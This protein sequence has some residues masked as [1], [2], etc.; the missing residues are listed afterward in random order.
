MIIRSTLFI[1]LTAFNGVAASAQSVPCLRLAGPFAVNRPAEIDSTDVNGK[2]FDM[3][4]LLDAVDIDTP[5]ADTFSGGRAPGLQGQTAV[6]VVSFYLNNSSYVKGQLTVSAPKHHSLYI[7]GEK[8]TAGEQTFT[9]GHHTVQLKYLVEPADSDSLCIGLDS[10]LLPLATTDEHH[11]YDLH[12]LFDGRRV[13]GISL[14]A[15]GRYAL[16]SYQTTQRGGNSEW[17]RALVETA[18]GRQLWLHRYDAETITWMPRSERLL[19]ETKEQG[20]RRL[21]AVD[22]LTDERQLIA[23][24][25]PEGSYTMSPTEDFLILYKEQKGPKEL[26]DDVFEIVDPDDRQPGHRDRSTLWRMDLRSG[27]CQPLLFGRGRTWVSS[28]SDDGRTALVAAARMRLERRPTTVTTYMLMDMQTLHID[29]LLCDAEF[30]D[31]GDLSPDG[32]HILFKGS[33]EAFDRVGCTLPADCTPQMMDYQ[34]YL[35]DI[36]TGQVT[37][38]TRDFDPSVQTVRWHRAN[39]M[40]YFT[41]ETG[42]RVLLYQLD[43]TRSGQRPTPVSGQQGDYIYAF[44]MAAM[45]PVACYLSYKTMEPASAY[46]LH[47]D[48][49]AAKGRRAA[50]RQLKLFDGATAIGTA[51]LG[52]CHDWTFLSARGDSVHGRYYLPADFD[53][54]RRYPMIVYYYGG[55][56]PVSRYFESPYAPQWWNALGYVAYILQPSGCTGYGQQWSARHVNTAGHGPAEDIIEGTRRFCREHSFIDST[57][58]GCMGASYGGFMTQYLQTQT[59]FFAAAVSHAGISNHASYWGE[60]YWGYS[61]SEVSM[62]NSYPWTHP[63]LYTRQSPLFMADKIH[64]PLLLLHGT[65]DTNVPIIESIQL[66]TALKLLGRPTALVEVKDQNH[67]ITDYKKRERWLWTQMAWFQRW[68]KGDSSWWDALYPK[69]TL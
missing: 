41:A 25:M 9:P 22:P 21:Y 44:G 54:S 6:G 20:V 56:S 23:D 57:R 60:G 40:I 47:L 68:L 1:L 5:A 43:P 2:A 18:T 10:L 4:T 38:L 63:E 58:V 19:M 69:K 3:A 7:D 27:V 62:A 17:Q 11:P 16:L 55:C 59:D 15:S 31:D 42:D 29:T 67:H 8:A 65:A 37:P 49:K 34:L 26:S 32:R 48:G 12:D 66:F 30:V 50:K 46:V 33:P 53:P 24:R 64:T 45:Q 39:N 13:R 61:Y 52:T 51:Q 14:S 36:A 28:I 35:Y